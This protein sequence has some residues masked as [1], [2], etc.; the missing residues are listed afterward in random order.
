MDTKK[1]IRR[2]QLALKGDHCVLKN[3]KILD[4]N[5]GFCLIKGPFRT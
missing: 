3:Q 5:E 1:A 2:N 4:V